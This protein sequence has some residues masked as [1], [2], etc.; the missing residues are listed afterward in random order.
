MATYGRV[1]EF[2]EDIETWDVYIERV[3]EYFAVNDTNEE[4]KKRSIL[5]SVCGSKTYNLVCN[6]LAPARSSEKSYQE[7]TELLKQHYN[8]RRSVIVQRFKFNSRV[9]Q[10]RESIAD[11]LVDLRRLSEHCQYQALEE[12]LR[13]H[14]VCGVS[15]TQIQRHLLAEGELTFKQAMDIATGMEL[16]E[17]NLVDIQQRTGQTTQLALE[18]NKPESLV[19]GLHKVY[20]QKPQQ[21]RMSCFHC[22]GSH[23]PGTCRW[24]QA[25]C[26]KCKTRAHQEMR[27][28]NVTNKF[29]NCGN[30]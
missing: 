25:V 5:L 15:N 12:M 26:H 27:K 19:A 4:S 6:L 28:P 18:T 24:K 1:D 3:D 11:F 16:A 21:S 30:N 13:D 9:Q 7:L 22:G 14:L 8:P 20:V 17:R 29:H 23:E 10:P 2:C